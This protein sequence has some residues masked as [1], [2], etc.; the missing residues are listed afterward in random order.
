MIEMINAPHHRD[1]LGGLGICRR[2]AGAAAVAQNASP[3][4]DAAGR[5]AAE[6]AAAKG[7]A[8]AN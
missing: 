2:S 6:R 8:T 3:G 4:R 5:I 7:S 1:F